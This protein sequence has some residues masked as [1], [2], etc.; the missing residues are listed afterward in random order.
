MVEYCD[1]DR[2][3]YRLAEQGGQWLRDELPTEEFEDP[4]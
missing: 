2:A 3:I 4:E 1:G